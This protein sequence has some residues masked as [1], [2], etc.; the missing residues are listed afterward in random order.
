MIYKIPNTFQKIY[1]KICWGFWCCV[2]LPE[3][4]NGVGLTFDLNKLQE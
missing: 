1:N 3:F 4:D 2:H